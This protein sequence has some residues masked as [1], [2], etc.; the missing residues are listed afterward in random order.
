[1][2]QVCDGLNCLSFDWKSFASW[3]PIF[4]YSFLSRHPTGVIYHYFWALCF[5]LTPASTLTSCAVTLFW[6]LAALIS[7]LSGW[8]SFDISEALIDVIFPQNHILLKMTSER[9]VKI[10]ISRRSHFIGNKPVW[11]PKSWI[12][13]DLL[14]VGVCPTFSCHFYWYCVHHHSGSRRLIYLTVSDTACNF[15][16]MVTISFCTLQNWFVPL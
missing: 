10:R 14:G 5:E 6:R 7:F 4:C 9:R 13:Q 8:L 1:M 11:N 15:W 16:S 12:S 2:I 3:S